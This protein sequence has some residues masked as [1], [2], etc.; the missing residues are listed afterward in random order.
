MKKN[1][2][3]F[4]IMLLSLS[5]IAQSPQAFNY[6]GIARDMSGN[7][8]PNQTI[9]LKFSILSDSPS[10]AVEFAEAH[11]LT[12]NDL[13]LFTI[14]VGQGTLLDGDMESI[15]WGDAPHFL[16]I[17][18]D[19]SGGTDYL[20]MGTTQ[21]LSVPYALHANNGSKWADFE[22]GIHFDQGNV[23]IGLESSDQR[24]RIEEGNSLL[25]FRNNG[26]VNNN[27]TQLFLGH[28]EDGFSAIYLDAEDGLG[29]GQDYAFL[30]H[31]N[32][33]SLELVNLDPS[34]IFFK[35]GGND[36]FHTRLTIS[37]LGDVG[38]DTT[39]PKSKLHVSDG[40]I[41][42]DDATKGVIMKSP[43]GQCWRMTV[44]NS[45]QPVFTFITCPD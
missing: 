45:G 6:Q 39:F 17:A 13:G 24:F 44:D 1:F 10:G 15:Q 4:A 23:A 3:V 18:M 36:Y 42:I 40:D 2:F 14:A 38:I 19:I 30:K 21:M 26:N 34:P 12:T 25:F 31:N 22:D 32:D 20:T 5:V 29:T 9:G 11:Q 27:G 37:A 7:P 35:T 8:V 33:L 28:K 16:E 43:N 41:Y